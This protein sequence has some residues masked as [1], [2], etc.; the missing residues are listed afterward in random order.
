MSIAIAI[1][2]AECTARERLAL[3]VDAGSFHEWL[4]PAER[5]SSP[6]LAQLGVPAAFDDEETC[7]IHRQ[8]VNRCPRTC[9]HGERKASATRRY[10]PFTCSPTASGTANSPRPPAPTRA[11]AHTHTHTHTPARTH[12]YARMHPHTRTHTNVPPRCSHVVFLE[13]RPRCTRQPPP[14]RRASAAKRSFPSR[15]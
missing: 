3:L 7:P 12:A 2:Y 10:T 11:L 8:P 6:H 13:A 4:P 1:S 9:D 5:V 14:G 15:P